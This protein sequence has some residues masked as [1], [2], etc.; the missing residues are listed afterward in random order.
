MIKVSDYIA[1]RIA[2]AGVKQVFSVVGGGAM[3]L[4]DSFNNNEDL[5]VIYCHHEQTCAMAVE[6]YSKVNNSLGCAVVTT[7]PGGTN[8]ITGVLGQWTDSVPA[9]YISGQVRYNT[10]IDST[11]IP[12][13]RQ[14]GDQEVNIISIVKPI[15]KF[16][17]MVKDPATIKWYMDKALYTAQNGRP[18]PV[19][20]D[21]PI[22][23]QSAMVDETTLNSWEQINQDTFSY[24]SVI[25]DID[26]LFKL[27]EQ[28]ERPVIY[29]GNGIRVA[30][31]YK[32]F[33]ELVPMIGIP[34]VTTWN[35]TD[36]LP[37]LNP[38]NVGRAGTIGTRSGNFAVQN[39]DLLIVLGSRLNI[40]QIGYEYK[41]FAREAKIVMVD[42]DLAEL[43]KP[44]ISPFLK[45]HSDLK[46]FIQEFIQSIKKY[47]IP[48]FSNWLHWCEDKKQRYPVVLDKY[49]N[50]QYGVNTY[51]AYD[52]LSNHLGFNEIII[53]ANG[54][55][56]VIGSQAIRLKTGSRMIG[57]SGCAA[58]GYELPASI[59]ACFANNK[60]RII[61]LA[62]DGSI[63]MN[64]QELQTIWYHNLPIKIILLNN[65]GYL[66]MRQ[67]QNN[68]FNGNRTG[69]SPQTGISFPN[70]EK[71]A[72][73]FKIPY[74]KITFTKKLNSC[75][76]EM[77]K[78]KGPFI[79]EIVVTSNQVFAPKVQAEKTPKGI[80][81]KPLEDMYPF[82]DRDEFNKN[83]IIKPW[84]KNDKT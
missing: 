48:D 34:V 19:W 53:Q 65:N 55:A 21:I 20:L 1:K 45:I 54:S 75:Y 42:I 82:L 49:K 26:T 71:I 80:V 74:N 59:G 61:C 72:S 4:N 32:E 11:G 81:S 17:A 64:L 7:G 24:Q 8:A 69:E 68:L 9:I 58:M 83:M 16:A 22:D 46:F 29:A 73:A 31:S 30:K 39:S 5:E 15:T 70:F 79:C 2:K 63:M 41:A 40:R 28:A 76:N 33:L 14:L 44:T 43:N 50:E 37:E 84:I 12:F 6:G 38:Y 67:T 23:V 25:S 27:I 66:S 3:Y 35:S 13:L 62:G 18:G 57:N 77:F 47:N 78:T 56:G 10:T 51:V 52:I 60:Q 36:I